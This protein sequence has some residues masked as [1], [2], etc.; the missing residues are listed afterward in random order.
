MKRG[1]L[2]S[3]RVLRSA[4]EVCVCVCVCVQVRGIIEDLAMEGLV[5]STVD[6]DHF[7]ATS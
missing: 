4:D 5:Y 2:S 7:A 6:E 1:V 3:E